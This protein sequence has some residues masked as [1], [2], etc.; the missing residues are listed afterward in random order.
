MRGSR[1]GDMRATRAL[2]L[3]ATLA[4][5]AVGCGGSGGA[6][7]SAVA[8][9]RTVQS[10]DGGLKLTV[11]VGA[12]AR[13]ADVAIK[14]LDKVPAELGGNKG[15]AYELTP[16]GLTF[17]KPVLVER[18]IDAKARGIDLTKGVPTV[19]LLSKS[20]GKWAPL[21]NL[22]V[23]V[24]GG[25]I[26]ATGT[27]MHFSTVVATN[28]GATAQLDPGEVEKYVGETWPATAE[29][30]D[31]GQSEIEV[32]H[33]A[34]EAMGAVSVVGPA[35]SDSDNVH[36]G[37]GTFE[38]AREG[39]GEYRITLKMIEPGIVGLFAAQVPFAVSVSGTALCNPRPGATSSPADVLDGGT[40]VVQHSQFGDF[41]SSGTWNV[42]FD[43]N[44][45]GSG[46]LKLTVQ[47]MND[48]K[49]TS[50]PVSDGKAHLQMGLRHY[51]PLRIDAA[52]LTS[53]GQQFDLLGPFRTY[54][55]A[56]TISSKQGVIAGQSD[57]CK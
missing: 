31:Q 34:R 37:L 21:D 9:P 53:N 16:D 20:A 10:S 30:T 29:I 49:E 28:L 24:D 12:T 8:Q 54:F 4:L 1:G 52:E 26:V 57:D 46:V 17:T 3:S 27:T 18:R 55:G 33:V 7:T 5:I 13:A 43:S 56:P 32:Q 25:T 48:G 38:C 11:P 40:L 15:T 14:V 41:P 39:T 2:A 47:G 23:R 36:K 45:V 19:V 6:K 51:G 22:D 42:C 50:T 44:R 35:V